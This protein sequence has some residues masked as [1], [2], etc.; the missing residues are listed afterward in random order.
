MSNDDFWMTV[1]DRDGQENQPRRFGAVRVALL[2]GTAAIAVAAI[3]T[4]IV[5]DRSTS[6]RVAWAPDQF[7]TITTG[8][9]PSH[10]KTKVYTVRKSILQDD[11]GAL[12]IIRSDGR[13]TGD[14]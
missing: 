8:S 7:D 2:F 9:I 4:P 1:M 14:C 12:C 10:S 11:P 3:L 5:A 13:K 6:A